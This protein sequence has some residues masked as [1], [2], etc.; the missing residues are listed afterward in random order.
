MNKMDLIDWD[1]EKFSVIKKK[2]NFYLLH[3]GFT[4]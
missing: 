1:E 2:L 3:I 4:E